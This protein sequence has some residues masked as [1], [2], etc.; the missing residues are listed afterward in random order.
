MLYLFLIIAGLAGGVLAGML[1]IGGGLVYVFVLEM[2][3]PQFGVS[4]DVLLATVLANSMFCVFFAALSSN[5]ALYRQ[6]EFYLKP[7]LLTGISA[8]VTSL[9]VLHFF[10]NTGDFDQKYFDI[11]MIFLLIYMLLRVVMKSVS[12]EADV[13]L[14]SISKPSFLLTGFGGGLVAALSGLGGGVVMVPVFNGLMKVNI[15]TA[16]SI[17]LGVIMITSLFMTIKN[18]LEPNQNIEYSL[19]LIVFSVSV[20]LSLGVIVGGPLGVFFSKKLSPK[21]ISGIYIFF[22]LYYISNKIWGVCSVWFL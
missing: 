19:G 6:K 18:L 10:V 21:V 16:R 4:E 20:I 22:L 15:K 7:V 1:G 13:Q 12:M 14:E 8:V 11:L 17:S 3:L 5:I 2:I 9:L